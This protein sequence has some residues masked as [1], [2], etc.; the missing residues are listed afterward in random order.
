M[1]WRFLLLLV[2]LLNPS[3]AHAGEDTWPDLSDPPPAEGGGEH[4]AAVIVGIENYT[5]VDDIPGAVHNANDWY[6]WLTRTRKVPLGRVKLL[7]DRGATREGILAAVGDAAEHVDRHGTL[8]FVFIGHG[9]PSR[10]GQDGLLLGHDTDQTADSVYARGLPRSELLDALSAGAQERTLVVL[11]TCFSGKGIDGDALVDGLM[12]LVPDYA[13]RTN[14][15]TVLTAGTGSQFAGPLPRAARPAFSYLVLGGLR[16]WADSSGDRQVTAAEAVDYAR[17]AMYALVQGRT[18]EPQLHGGDGDAALSRGRESGPDLPAMVLAAPGSGGVG[19]GSTSVDYG[20]GGDVDIR[21]AAAEADRIA[22]ERE[23]LEQRERELREQ[24]EQDQRRRLQEAERALRAAAEDEW[25]ALADLRE[26]GAAEAVGVVELYAIKYEGATVTAGGLTHAV[27]IALVDEAHDWL[28]ERGVRT[29][30][31]GD[32]GGPV[33]DAHGYEMVRIGPGEFLMGSPSHEEGRSDD[34]TR[35]RVQ[36]TRAFAIGSTEVTQGLYEAVVGSN[37][38]DCDRGCSADHP[39][40]NV[41]WLD[42]VEFCNRLSRQEGYTEAYRIRRHKVKQVPDADGYRLPTEAEWE[43]AARA[44]GTHLYSGS[45]DLGSVGWHQGN[46]EA[47]THP[48]AQKRANAWGLYDMSGNVREWVEDVRARYPYVRGQVSDP[49]G[50][51][52]GDFRVLRGGHFYS[53]E[54]TSRSAHRSGGGQST[55]SMFS[56]FRVVLPAPEPD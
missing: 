40:Q 50:P 18:Q 6:A 13:I 44:G 16:G 27:E 56:G 7:R 9:A 29:P 23:A 19:T 46:S 31:M 52:E 35:H 5:F 51:T 38:S 26:S 47:K 39:V 45:D 28:R 32:L 20:P 54:V 41:S 17:D 3:V 11:D 48:V 22:R 14:T 49:T 34:E 21:A 55:P 43:Y 37:P 53:G 42:A 30:G 2:F 36:L 24:V 1:R 10:D 25:L 15:A 33:V 12:P 8:W 4:D